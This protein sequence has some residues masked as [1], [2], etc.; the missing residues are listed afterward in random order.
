[1][2]EVLA[3]G[4]MADRP[5]TN[6]T[7]S[8]LDIALSILWYICWPIGVLLY[9]VA[10]AVIT[11]IKL[12]YQ[13]V[14]FLLQPLIIVG[15]FILACLLSPFRLLVKFEVYG[16]HNPH[17]VQLLIVVADTLHICRHRSHSWPGHWS[18]RQV[19]LWLAHQH[20]AP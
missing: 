4:L 2:S 3:R 13:P 15:H 17:F 20:P 7:A 5:P 18:R 16:M 11:I 14:A 8:Y 1:M 9:Y 12:L 10:I 19:H 6:G